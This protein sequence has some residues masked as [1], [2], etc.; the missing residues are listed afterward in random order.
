MLHR[1]STYVLASSGKKTQHLN[2]PGIDQQCRVRRVRF[3][4]VSEKSDGMVG[5]KPRI[6]RGVLIVNSTDMGTPHQ[7]RY[8]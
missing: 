1:Q 2:L 5:A 8:R 3:F 7:N 6:G 4:I